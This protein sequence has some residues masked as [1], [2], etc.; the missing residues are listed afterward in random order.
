MTFAELLAKID[1][2][3]RNFLVQNYPSFACLLYSYG[4]K[5]FLNRLVSDKPRPIALPLE[6]QRTFWDITFRTPLFNAAGM[7]KNG[8]GY[9]LAWLQGAGAFLAGTVTP[10]PRFGNIKN[11]I[12]HPFLPYPKSQSSSNWMGLPNP[13]YKTVVNRLAKLAK[14]KGVPIGLSLSADG[15]ELSNL[16]ELCEVLVD[17][18]KS[19][20]DFVELNESCPNVDHKGLDL[21]Q[22]DKHFLARIEFISE[23]FL[24]KRKR[25]LPVIVKLSNDFNINFVPDLIET[26]V[27]LHFDGVNFGNTSTNYDECKFHI[28]PVELDAFQF[29]I[30]TFGGGVSGNPLKNKSFELTKS[31]VNSLKNIR[32]AREFHIVRTGGISNFGDYIKSAELGVS[33]FQW[34]TGY[35]ENFAI[36]GHKLYKDFFCF[37]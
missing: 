9:E 21:T 24:K 19:N 32:L 25:N 7:F 27:D 30:R 15:D 11:G 10:N 5:W 37:K 31:A 3:I 35:F 18:E 12:L 17:V 20:V 26:L 4:R 6:L 8:K 28:N 13:G 2:P 33:L 16:K 36:F 22:L 34:F 1:I 23:N 29:F 14:Q